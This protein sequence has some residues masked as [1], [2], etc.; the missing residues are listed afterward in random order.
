MR[1][2]LNICESRDEY[3]SDKH[4]QEIREI[5]VDHFTGEDISIDPKTGAV[6]V[7]CNVSKKANWKSTTFPV[8][9][10]DIRG[11]FEC[12]SRGLETLENGP[13]NVEGSYYIDRNHLISL[14]Y[15]PKG[16]IITLAIS[17]LTL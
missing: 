2:W 8:K 14:K 13:T 15:L 7:D 3:L 16:N 1:K 11:S 17:F 6:S 9:L 10:G 12:D 4:I 5:Y